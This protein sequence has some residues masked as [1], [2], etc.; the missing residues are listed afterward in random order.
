LFRS[1]QID[2]AGGYLDSRPKIR[3]A[4]DGI[5]KAAGRAQQSLKNLPRGGCRKSSGEDFYFLLKRLNIS[6]LLVIVFQPRER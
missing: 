1:L 5:P 2:G 3:L 4:G 6:N